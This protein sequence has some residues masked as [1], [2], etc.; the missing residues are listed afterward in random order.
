MAS[1]AAK[2]AAAT[3]KRRAAA[4]KATTTRKRRAAA[5]STPSVIPMLSYED[6]IAALTDY[7]SM[8]DDEGAAYRM[9]GFAYEK[10]RRFAEARDA[11]R[12]GIEAASKHHHPSMANEF[13]MKLQDLEDL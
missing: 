13:E 7:L 12:Q 11:Y 5:A 9:L 6:G 8:N 4:S 1:S 2:K 10:L 3:R